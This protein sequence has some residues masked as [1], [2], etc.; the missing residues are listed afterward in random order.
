MAQS[1]PS[2]NPSGEQQRRGITAKDAVAGL[3]HNNNLLL[4][5]EDHGRFHRRQLSSYKIKMTKDGRWELVAHRDF[6]SKLSRDIDTSAGMSI[7]VSRELVEL[8]VYSTEKKIL[9]YILSKPRS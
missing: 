1:I 5:L 2:R 3:I 4:C 7:Q 9:R 6:H 8:V